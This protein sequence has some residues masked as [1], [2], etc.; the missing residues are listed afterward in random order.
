MV[1][2]SRLT[3]RWADPLSVRQA[4]CRDPSVH[5]G[6]DRVRLYGRCAWA[7]VHG[8]FGGGRCGDGAG[9]RRK[10]RCSTPGAA[11]T[12]DRLA[13]GGRGGARACPRGPA[14]HAHERA[15]RGGRVG[16]DAAWSRQAEAFSRT[17]AREL[18]RARLRR[19]SGP[20][21]RVSRGQQLPSVVDAGRRRACPAGAGWTVRSQRAGDRSA[22]ARR[23][24]ALRPRS[25]RSGRLLV[26]RR[27]G[28]S[29]SATA[30][31]SWMRS[32]ARESTTIGIRS[33]FQLPAGHGLSNL[34]A[35]AALLRKRQGN[36][37][38]SPL[39]LER[40]DADN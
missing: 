36:L 11:R 26:R 27:A 25:G 35:A 24:C 1:K 2:E 23:R 31:A 15:R 5:A 21:E 28:W 16:R 30:S 22:C 39:V 20:G 37:R 32:P 8:G 19:R 33:P 9:R 13:D 14:R 3:T 17:E 4:S 7:F 6:A 34:R 18:L 40:A 12:G 10:P 38:G 29:C